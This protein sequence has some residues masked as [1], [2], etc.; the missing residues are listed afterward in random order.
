MRYGYYMNTNRVDNRSALAA[1]EAKRLEHEARIAKRRAQA[2]AVFAAIVAAN[3]EG[4]FAV[5]AER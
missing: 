3:P 4:R 5:K 1:L 2:D